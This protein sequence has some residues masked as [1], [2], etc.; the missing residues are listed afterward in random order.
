MLIRLQSVPSFSYH[1]FVRLPLFLFFHT[2]CDCN[3]RTISERQRR[4]IISPLLVFDSCSPD[5]YLLS[6]CCSLAFPDSWVL[7]L[8]LSEE[9]SMSHTRRDNWHEHSITC[10]CSH[11]LSI[12][13]SSVFLPSLV[14]S[15]SL[16]VSSLDQWVIPCRVSCFRFRLNNISSCLSSICSPVLLVFQERTFVVTA[17]DVSFF[18]R[19]SRS[20]VKD[21]PWYV[22]LLV[23]VSVQAAD[24]LESDVSGTV[25]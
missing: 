10:F 2:L 11:F 23:F 14:Q 15:C 1:C 5:I 8:R 18:Q 20:H 19:L 24:S 25:F 22:C 13:G 9:S 3:T 6:E 21:S 17:L 7:S 4:S 16:V 12:W